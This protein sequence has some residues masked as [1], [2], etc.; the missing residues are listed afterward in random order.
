MHQFQSAEKYQ[1][2]TS[3]TT[4]LQT[5]ATT[6]PNIEL[7]TPSLLLDRDHP[8]A[9]NPS[10]VRYAPSSPLLSHDYNLDKS[11]L[12]PEANEPKKFVTKIKIRITLSSEKKSVTQGTNCLSSPTLCSSAK[13][14]SPQNQLGETRA[15]QKQCSITNPYYDL[16]ESSFVKKP[17]EAPISYSQNENFSQMTSPCIFSNQKQRP[18]EETKAQADPAP[19]A[20]PKG[21]LNILNKI[22]NT[23]LHGVAKPHKNPQ[24]ESHKLLQMPLSKKLHPEER[25]S[26]TGEK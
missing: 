20:Q 11:T 24:N 8:P 15:T 10:S 26:Q 5:P 2:T 19:P 22:L 17:A 14:F 4:N 13:D 23:K 3:E 25:V 21:S 16:P 18:V 1:A 7:K 9:T 6:T 12:P